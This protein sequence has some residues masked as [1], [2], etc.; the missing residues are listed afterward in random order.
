MVSHARRLGAALAA[1]AVLV[2][3]CG[4]SEPGASTN[5]TS[6]RSAR[7]TA[8]KPPGSTPEI[9]ARS[10]T[11]IA[12]PTRT[13]EP[14]AGPGSTP[15][16][17]AST[18][19]VAGEPESSG[20][21][22][23]AFAGDVNFEERTADRLAAGPE[24]A[25]GVAKDQL[26]A[27]DLTMVNLETA[28]TTRGEK[29]PKSFTFR[30]PAG[31]LD[32]LAYAGVDVAT[33]ANNHADSPYLTCVDYGPQGLQDTLAAIDDSPVP[34]IGIGKNQ[35]AAFAPYRRTVHGVRIAVFAATQVMD[36][37]KERWSATADSPGVANADRQQLI[38]DVR[39]AR[40]AGE[41]PIV[42]LHWGTEYVGCPDDPQRRLAA[43]LADAGAVAVIGTHAH[44]L[45]GAGWRDD[46]VYV[47]YGLGNYLW[48]RSFGNEQDDNG[49]LTLTFT[50]AKVTA[51]KFVPAHL[52]DT[53]VPVPATGQTKQRIDAEWERV[54]ACADL[55]ATPPK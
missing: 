18:R 8:E 14:S 23:F 53:G 25:F 5:A 49:V 38:D 42:Y 1:G 29:Q 40:K 55:S 28:I 10:M 20:T 46:G 7:D 12:D 19:I 32:A 36:L 39:A 47:A 9:T 35:Q 3:G 44:V 16:P 24:N 33:M 31:A 41:V 37:T 54:R 48:W 13:E 22:T 50:G 30:A 27:A 51:A 4:S 21:F 34:V 45:Q 26:A 6:M 52:D 17:T 15:S 11:S 2:A 43:E